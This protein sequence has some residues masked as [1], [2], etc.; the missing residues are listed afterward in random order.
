[1]PVGLATIKLEPLSLVHKFVLT[2][3]A[4][5]GDFQLIER[6][7]VFWQDVCRSPPPA[8]TDHQSVI[9]YKLFYF[10]HCREIINDRLSFAWANGRSG[11]HS[12]VY[13][14]IILNKSFD[15]VPDCIIMS[16]TKRGKLSCC[17][18]SSASKTSPIGPCVQRHG[19]VRTSCES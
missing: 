11:H 9:V 6:L 13:A 12:K 19:Q 10:C 2:L 7:L 16:Y 14:I 15:V 4:Q 8:K 17:T 18:V 3:R 5:S 1:M